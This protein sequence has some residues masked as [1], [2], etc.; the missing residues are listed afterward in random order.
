MPELATPPESL[1]H[2]VMKVTEKNK[3]DIESRL[4]LKPR[5][6]LF[7]TYKA[8]IRS[9][10]RKAIWFLSEEFTRRGVP[11]VFRPSPFYG[12]RLRIPEQDLL[13]LDLQWLVETYLNHKPYS[14]R[15]RKLFLTSTFLGAADMLGWRWPKPPHSFVRMLGVSERQ[16]LEM[17][18]L[19]CKPIKTHRSELEQASHAVFE[20]LKVAHNA[21]PR[22][23]I[24]QGT[25]ETIQRRH[26]IWWCGNLA[27]WF[28]QDTANHYYRKTG[29]TITRSLANK[30]I[31]EVWGH[32]PE[33]R[34]APKRARRSKG[35]P[36][37]EPTK[38]ET[39]RRTKPP[40]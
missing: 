27:D 28:P 39:I 9:E 16:Q 14:K 30:I 25:S 13:F 4:K 19:M 38:R 35:K 3:T 23:R 12:G 11:P 37:I 21:R 1:M 20:R 33:S 7:E 22:A 24:Q 2:L 31:G 17:S 40:K 34:P 32:I 26:D 6:A 18:W 36:T 10:N 15:L 5:Q 29:E 8:F